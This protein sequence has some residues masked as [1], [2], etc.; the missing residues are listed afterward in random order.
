M[1]HSIS[2]I[3][4]WSSQDAL[5]KGSIL[6][7]SL[8]MIKKVKGKYRVVSKSGKNLGE[9]LSISAARKRLGQVEYFKKHG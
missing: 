1:W 6:C 5:F 9:Y 4:S 8:G 2:N 7:Y 3:G